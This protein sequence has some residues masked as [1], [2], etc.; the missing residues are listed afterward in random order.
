M[1]KHI[2]LSAPRHLGDYTALTNTLFNLHSAFPEHTY[3][4][5]LRGCGSFGDLFLNNPFLTQ[6]QDNNS[7]G[8]LLHYESGRVDESKGTHGC[9][10]K[11]FHKMAERS[12]SVLY[13]DTIRFPMVK[14]TADFY[15]DPTEYEQY[16]I[17]YKDYCLL[18]ANAQVCADTKGYPYWQEVVDLCPDIQFL[19]MGGDWK[20]IPEPPLKGVVDL[21]GKTTVRQLILLASKA[22]YILSG[23]S[24]IVHIGSAFP[25]VKK[26]VLTG[27]R[28]PATFYTYPNT[29]P[30]YTRC[31]SFGYKTGC[32]SMHFGQSGAWTCNKYCTEGP[33]TY[34]N[35]MC[36][37]APE[38]IVESMCMSV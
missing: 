13:Q 34:A 6:K 9:Y 3:S 23:P 7:W 5:D 14:I 22:K 37:I 24:G 27:A 19:Q 18:N 2:I 21:R 29:V 4:V 31:G 36:S 20:D 38:Q 8:I 33:R 30:V 25:D 15:I 10:T 11:G 12:M 32:I 17:P 1:N 26:V 28:D 16:D 35:C